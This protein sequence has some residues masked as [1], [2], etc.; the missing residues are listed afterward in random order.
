[1]TPLEPWIEE[2]EAVWRWD[3]MEGSITAAQAA[4]QAGHRA[5]LGSVRRRERRTHARYVSE[6]Q[7][8]G[9]GSDSRRGKGQ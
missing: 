4:S 6:I 9:L 2:E 3:N 1:M 8:T 7:L 5:E